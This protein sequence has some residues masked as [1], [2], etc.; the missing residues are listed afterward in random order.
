MFR[1]RIL[2]VLV[3]FI[4]SLLHWSWRKIIIEPDSLKSALA[5]GEPLIMAHWHGDELAV[6]HL[7]R[8]YRLA[9]M[10]STSRDGSLIDFVIRAFGGKTVRGSSTRGGASAL[11]G[12]VRLTKGGHPASM[13]VDGPKGPIY[14]VKPGVFELSR[15]AGAQIFPVSVATNSKHIFEKSWNKAY[16]PLPFAR[17]AIVYG[18][19]LPVVTREQDPKAPELAQKL[20]VAL[21]DA[22]QQAS[23]LIAQ[24]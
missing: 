3:W 14:Q 18:D 23:K 4:Y 17:V 22:K 6:L 24:F 16:L 20:S 12:L 11:K 7:V 15:L 8:R 1:R 13:A 9:T 10:T 2:P 21:A 5:N 19:P